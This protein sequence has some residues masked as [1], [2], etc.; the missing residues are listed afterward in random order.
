MESI[1]NKILNGLLKQGVWAVLFVVLVYMYTTD[2]KTANSYLRDERANDQKLYI[3]ATDKFHKTMNNYLIKFEDM[4]G[5]IREL[6]EDE[7]NRWA[8]KSK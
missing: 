6:K 2:L 8:N 7:K 3:E 4:A 1:N 5:D